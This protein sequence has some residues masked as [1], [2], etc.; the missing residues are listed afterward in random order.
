MLE[1]GSVGTIH[2]AVLVALADCYISDLLQTLVGMF[3]E[4]EGFCSCDYLLFVLNKHLNSG[5]IECWG[6]LLVVI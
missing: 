2:G 3:L 6:I 4:L 5:L 1:R